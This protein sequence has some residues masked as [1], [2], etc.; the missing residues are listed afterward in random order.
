MSKMKPDRDFKTSMIYLFGVP[1]FGITRHASDIR[2]IYEGQSFYIDRG[3]CWG[4]H[5]LM[6]L[7]SG[8]IFKGMT[9]NCLNV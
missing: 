5:Q 2:K 1:D 8:K 3:K 6:M 7:R 9:I 4:N